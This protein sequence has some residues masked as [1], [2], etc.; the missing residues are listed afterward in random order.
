MLRLWIFKKGDMSRVIGTVAFNNI[1]RGAF[2]S[3][4]L[5]YKLDKDEINKGYAT[6]AIRKGI[7]IIFNY[8]GLHRIEANI[9]PRNT[10]FFTC[11]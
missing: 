5:G 3:C 4:H 2:L 8:Y 1:I 6:E 11:R 7:D 10:P 9:M